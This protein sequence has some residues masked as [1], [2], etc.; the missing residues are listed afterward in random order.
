M[1]RASLREVRS[2]DDKSGALVVIDGVEYWQPECR[3]V[4]QGH[5]CYLR[6]MPQTVPISIDKINSRTNGSLP[7]ELVRDHNGE[8]Q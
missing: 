1:T 3:C 7:S 2:S 6:P 5:I 8:E 4:G